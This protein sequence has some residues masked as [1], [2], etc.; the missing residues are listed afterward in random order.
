MQSIAAGATH[1]FGVFFFRFLEAQKPATRISSHRILG[2]FWFRNLRGPEKVSESSSLRGQFFTDE[3]HCHGA[4]QP[5][6]DLVSP[7]YCN[8]LCWF[9]FPGGLLA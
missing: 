4:L 3:L 7:L 2:V 5:L 8:G 6:C 9:A 1:K